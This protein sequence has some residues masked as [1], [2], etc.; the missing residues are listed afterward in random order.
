MMMANI[1]T[2]YSL[3]DFALKSDLYFQLADSNIVW[4]INFELSCDCLV[5]FLNILN[6][7][8]N[9]IDSSHKIIISSEYTI[10]V[11]EVIRVSD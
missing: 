2:Y 11:S 3:F 6:V 9:A 4:V 8:F 10:L 7:I 5:I 1:P